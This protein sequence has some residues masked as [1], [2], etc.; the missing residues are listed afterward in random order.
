M[1][2]RAYND[3]LAAPL[4]RLRHNFVDMGDIGAGGVEH[5]NAPF[6]EVLVNRPALPVRAD[7][8]RSS[9]GHLLRPLHR[10]QPLDGQPVHHIPIVDDRA[11]HNAGDA[12]GRF[13]LRQLH[14][15]AHAVAKTGGLGQN[16]FHPTPSPRACTRSIRSWAITWSSSAVGLRPSYSG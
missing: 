9:V 7:D 10:P 6:G 13:F 8:D 5:R 16:H 2:R 14:R 4:L 3:R 12:L 11:Q 15:P 1:V